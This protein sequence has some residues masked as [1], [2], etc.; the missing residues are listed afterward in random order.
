MLKFYSTNEALKCK[1]SVH[2]FIIICFRS[3]EKWEVQEDSHSEARNLRI[4]CTPLLEKVFNFDSEEYISPRHR[5]DIGVGS[6][7]AKGASPS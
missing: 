7:G 3:Q 4:G 2:S 1:P 5:L 6:R